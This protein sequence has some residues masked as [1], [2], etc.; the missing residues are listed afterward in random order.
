MTDPNESPFPMKE[1]KLEPG[2]EPLVIVSSIPWVRLTL[3][4]W[5]V[6][7]PAVVAAMWLSGGRGQYGYTTFMAVPVVAGFVCGLLVNA[8]REWNGRDSCI[9]MTLTCGAVV[10]GLLLMK[11]EGMVCL[12]MASML[13][14]GLTL[15]GLALAWLLRSVSKDKPGRRNL[16]ILAA[17][18]I[19]LCSAV[20]T[21]LAPQ[22]SLIE[23]TTV[24]EIDA[25]P[26]EVWKYV[27]GFPEIT[28]RPGW[29]Y[30][31]GVAY[32]LRSKVI[33]SGVGA[34]R[35]CV[36]STGVMDETVTVWEPGRRLEFDVLTVP[37]AMHEASVHGELET[38]HLNGYFVP[39]RGRFVL[40]ELPSGRTRLEGT[41][42]YVH[43][44][45]PEW[46][47][48][49]VTQ[50]VVRGIHERVLLHIKMLA[51][52]ELKSIHSFMLVRHGQVVEEKW[53]APE[54]PEK[55]HEMWSLSNSFAV[56]WRRTATAAAAMGA[57]AYF[58]T[59]GLHREQSGAW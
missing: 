26:S 23:Q 42:W 21:R 18:S 9:G 57:S 2:E 35:S 59:P 22:P 40:V 45:W 53:W 15:L 29:L 58:G 24:I 43:Q 49:P 17:C 37:P 28:A 50:R 16:L 3:V 38:P 33:G 1:R 5:L 20:E 30:R 47:W 55:P 4:A 56:G 27:P 32:P 41:S 10:I 14:W 11:V 8:G 46:Y 19:P 7:V 52:R 39:Q 51:E 44:I 6:G 34:K 36:L 54:G 25:P 12:L 31:A 48:T 13:L